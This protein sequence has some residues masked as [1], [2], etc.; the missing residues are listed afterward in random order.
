MQRTDCFGLFVLF[1]EIKAKIFFVFPFFT[2]PVGAN[3]PLRVT[4]GSQA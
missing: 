2:K 1:L 3:P 4:K